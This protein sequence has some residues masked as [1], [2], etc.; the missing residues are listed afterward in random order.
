MAHQTPI[1]RWV[2]NNRDRLNPSFVK[3]DWP[4]RYFN[5]VA[6]FAAT[7]SVDGIEAFGRGIDTDQNLA[8]EKSAAEAVERFI[9]QSLKIDS[10]GVAVSGEVGAVDHAERE[11]LERHFFFE[12]Q[13]LQ[14]PFIP[15]ASDSHGLPIVAEIIS[16][17]DRRNENAGKL[18]FF[19]MAA[20]VPYHGYVATIA[21][22][23]Q[24]RFIGLAL[25]SD[26]HKSVYRAFFEAMANFARFRDDAPKFETEWSSNSDAWT[27]DPRYLNKLIYL[28]SEEAQSGPTLL[29]PK[30]SS[31]P[32]NISGLH[33]L[34]GCPISPVKVVVV[35]E[36]AL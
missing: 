3:F 25:H 18:T 21:V 31:V 2:L 30:W 12:H 34:S 1:A 36:V 23:G 10:V 11:A 33:I 32:L 28:F 22:N 16:A 35:S 14:R 29:L 5:G 24:V 7:I 15:V 9:C 13:R 17:F 8:I 20:P 19:K 27:C 6:D 4:T 26:A